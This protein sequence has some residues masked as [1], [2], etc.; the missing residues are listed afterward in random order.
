MTLK[1]YFSAALLVCIASG[2]HVPAEGTAGAEPPLEDPESMALYGRLLGES[3]GLRVW[4]PRP[5]SLPWAEALGASRPSGLQKSARGGGGNVVEPLTVIQTDY[6]D[7]EAGNVVL[8]IW[9]ETS[10]NP[11]GVDVLVD[12]EVVATY[13]NPGGP[14][15]V[16]IEFVFVTG[17]E[18]GDR[19]FGV[20]E[21]EVVDAPV[22]EESLAILEEKPFSDPESLECR[23][24]EPGD[25]GCELRISWVNPGPLP[26]FG[27]VLVDGEGVGEVLT[28][29]LET[30]VRVSGVAAGSHTSS[31]FGFLEETPGVSTRLYRGSRVDTSC[32][33]T[34]APLPCEAPASLRICQVAHGS[35]S[36]SVLVDWVTPAAYYSQG[37]T[38]LVDGEVFA[39]VQ[40]PPGASGITLIGLEPGVR[41]FGIRGDCGPDGV[42]SDVTEQTFELLADTPHTN[43]VVGD[44]VCSF[45]D[46]AGTTR[47]TWENAE[48]SDFIDV[49]LLAPGAGLSF[50][51]TV[52][53]GST[54]LT[55]EADASAGEVVVLQF[56]ATSASQ[57]HGSELVF[58]GNRFIRGACSGE[59][60]T[61]GI[62]DAILYLRYLFT[63]GPK[64]ICLAACDVDANGAGDI[65][66]PVYLLN[67]LFLGGPAP[68]GWTDTEGD[69]VLRPVCE[70]AP[71]TQCLESH[72]FC[73]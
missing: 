19:T 62:S 16:P 56:F 28:D 31:V 47:V 11:A 59:S 71:A 48:P 46:A 17:V 49:F 21:A 20:R 54:E 53:G 57:C 36:N 73:D 5:Q 64:P 35:E 1:A 40:L 10:L 50:L 12:G 55:V 51:R 27:L 33:I 2:V 60:P 30:E 67:Y 13:L 14:T 32:D 26:D 38:V 37:V 39:E 18:A 58:C 43:P 29:S 8:L 3:D 6:A 70:A 52:P 7:P 24:G 22:A 45:D 44:P 25:P 66:D 63:G 72:S 68:V 41:T 34:C 42:T 9:G 65:S 4:A 61:P 15:P 69:G 23:Q